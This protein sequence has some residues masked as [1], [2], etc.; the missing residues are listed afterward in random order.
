V[1]VATEDGDTEHAIRMYLFPRRDSTDVK[2]L[3][4]EVGLSR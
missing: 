2:Q 1:D 4:G 3:T